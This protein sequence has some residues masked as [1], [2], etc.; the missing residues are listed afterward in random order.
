MDIAPKPSRQSK[1]LTLAIDV[2]GTRLK[3][4]LLSPSGEMVAG[5]N[6]VNTPDSPTPA[7]VVEIL[8]GLATPLGHFDRIS[9]GFPGVVRNGHVLTAP[10]LGTE[11]WRRFPLA[12]TLAEKLGKPARMLNDAEVQGLGVVTGKGLECVITLGTG[13]GFSLFMDGHPAPHLELS[14]HPIHKGKTYD[15]YIGVAA[16]RKVGRK[17]WNRRVERALA[18]ITTL[19]GYDVLYI[20]GGN[21]KE[22]TLDLPANVQIVSNQ[23]G[24]T[25]GVRLW[26]KRLDGLF[27]EG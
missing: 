16:Y 7:A 6:R 26:D 21:A 3:A 12:A 9:I 27:V 11:D 8:V 24:I 10:N 2:G 18:C 20:G 1:P 22:L 13:M 5:P 17:H 14:Q 23:A 15:Q 4:G 19:V 25:G